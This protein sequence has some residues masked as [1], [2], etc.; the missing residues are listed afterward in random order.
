MDSG[1]RK[2]GK[3]EYAIKTAQPGGTWRAAAFRIYVCHTSE[4]VAANNRQRVS[5]CERRSAAATYWWNKCRRGLPEF[6]HWKLMIH[7]KHK[8]IAFLEGKTARRQEL[9][10]QWTILYFPLHHLS[11]LACL[12]LLPGL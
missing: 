12:L 11:P 6:F 3:E 9:S 10:A 4:T 2:K 7:S 8:R 5:I 1:K